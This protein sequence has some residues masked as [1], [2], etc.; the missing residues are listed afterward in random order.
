MSCV[1][2]T[3]V[4]I[5]SEVH[6]DDS[7]DKTAEMLID[8]AK[9]DIQRRNP[10]EVKISS[11]WILCLSEHC[12]VTMQEFTLYIRNIRCRNVRKLIDHTGLY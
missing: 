4:N 11:D 3:L 12:N 5:T 9:T 7:N 1:D 10:P 2:D 6:S 8:L